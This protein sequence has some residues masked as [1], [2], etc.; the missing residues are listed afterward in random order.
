M[1]NE[2]LICLMLLDIKKFLNNH[3]TLF[4]N[5]QHNIGFYLCMTNKKNKDSETILSS[6]VYSTNF[7]KTWFRPK[8]ET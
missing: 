4:K 8:A 2:Q 6:K 7:R 3:A 5:F 1:G